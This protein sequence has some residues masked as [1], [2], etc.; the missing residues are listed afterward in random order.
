MP[1]A[2]FQLAELTFPTFLL[3]NSMDMAHANSDAVLFYAPVP[4]FDIGLDT[5][6]YLKGDG[7]SVECSSPTN[8]QGIATERM[9]H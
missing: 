3:F 8:G 5:F 7:T 2:D 9:P 4:H 1:L 6:A